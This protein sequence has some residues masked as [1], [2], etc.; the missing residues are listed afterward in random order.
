MGTLRAGIAV[1][2][3]VGHGLREGGVLPALADVLRR[4]RLRNVLG[5]LHAELDVGQDAGHGVAELGQHL[6]EELE[7]IGITVTLLQFSP[8]MEEM[9][10]FAAEVI[11]L[12]RGT[13]E[14]VTRS[15]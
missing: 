15:A 4:A 3:A 13:V 5:A 7:R 10:R 1:A 11:P 12:V 6:L 2:V 14:P 8:Q 9:E